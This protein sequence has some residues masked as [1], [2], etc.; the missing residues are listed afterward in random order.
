MH[1]TKIAAKA[2]MD[3]TSS[4]QFNM[5]IIDCEVG[6]IFPFL[7]TFQEK[8][9]KRN[10]K[11]HYQAKRYPNSVSL[12]VSFSQQEAHSGFK[13]TMFLVLADMFVCFLCILKCNNYNQT[14]ELVKFSMFL[15]ITVHVK[16]YWW[17]KKICQYTVV[18]ESL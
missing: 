16:C 11:S 14:W 2:S 12:S 9:K 13:W 1:K 3:L 6:Q 8:K 7:W 5:K 15:T 17:M 10:I 18:L 4:R